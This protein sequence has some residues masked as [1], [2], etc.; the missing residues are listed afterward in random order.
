MRLTLTLLLT[1]VTFSV[2]FL[3]TFGWRFDEGLDE[4]ITVSRDVR[5][6][7]I[8]LPSYMKRFEHE[9]NEQLLRQ[10]WLNTLHPKILRRHDLPQSLF[11]FPLWKER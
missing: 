8:S 1:V 7:E 3:H 10:I 4:P 5:A 9:P 6:K 2:H 11:Y